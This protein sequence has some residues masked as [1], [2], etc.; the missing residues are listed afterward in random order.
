MV[1]TQQRNGFFSE[2][3]IGHWL[4]VR[5]ER[6]RQGIPTRHPSRG[7]VADHPLTGAI[8][9]NA[10]GKLYTVESVRN[11]WLA[12]WVEA[13]TLRDEQGS[14]ATVVL[15]NVSSIS[16]MMSRQADKFASDFTLVSND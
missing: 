8:F 12:G 2:V 9:R 14:H 11:D 15:R 16:E 5:K 6:E 13:A 4:L 3:N 1:I 7:L 10:N